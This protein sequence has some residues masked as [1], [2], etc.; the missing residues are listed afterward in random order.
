M[1]QRILQQCN[2]WYILIF[3]YIMRRQCR[4]IMYQT[5]VFGA[6]CVDALRFYQNVTIDTK[7]VNRWHILFLIHFATTV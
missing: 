3:C 1:I 4:R 5:E 2:N 7:C 6:K